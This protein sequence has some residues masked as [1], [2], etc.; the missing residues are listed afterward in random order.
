M[1]SLYSPYKILRILTWQTKVETV[2][3]SPEMR[4]KE[5]LGFERKRPVTKQPTCPFFPNAVAPPHAQRSTL[6]GPAFNDDAG[7]LYCGLAKKSSTMMY[8]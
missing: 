2:L 6:A 4:P 1:L 8:T 7:I 5:Y 3:Q